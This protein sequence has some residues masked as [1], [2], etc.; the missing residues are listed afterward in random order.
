MFTL[1]VEHL[2]LYIKNKREIYFSYSA[3]STVI[4]VMLM[5]V[6][7]K[8]WVYMI[9]VVGGLLQKHFLTFGGRHLF[10]P[11]NVSIV[12][13]LLLFYDKAHL[14]LGQL[15]D[16]LWIA[17]FV[18][19]SALLI[20]WRVKRWVIPLAFCL[21]Y[22]FF[23]YYLVIRHDPVM[24]VE[25]FLN[26]FLSVS[27]LVFIVFML[28]DPRTTPERLECQISFAVMIALGAAVLDAAHGFRVQ[29]LF[30]SLTFCSPWV[31]IIVLYHNGHH[32][33]QLAVIATLTMLFVVGA[34]LL[35]EKQ[36]SYYYL[37]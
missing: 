16:D 6:S 28:T 29:H 14:V 18:L 2:F 8:L 37:M 4:G 19:A 7:F 9:V 1:V 21:A 11:S 30:L 23:E 5:M 10:N 20:L 32:R 17:V 24:I 26:R 12:I 33:G 25:D 22:V 15:G 27:F 35:I 36:P 3:L 13:A 34:L 31:A